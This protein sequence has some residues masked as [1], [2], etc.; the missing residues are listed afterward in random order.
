MS[1]RTPRGEPAEGRSQASTMSRPADGGPRTPDGSPRETME[2]GEGDRVIRIQIQ[3]PAA[4]PQAPTQPRQQP[5]GPPGWLWLIIAVIGLIVVI[6]AVAFIVGAIQG[7]TGAIHQQTGQLAQQ[8]QVLGQ[9]ARGLNTL[10]QTIQQAVQAILGR[11]PA[12]G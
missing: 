9:I 5:S 6:A 11:L 4:T 10:I 1:I 8:S 12:K 7:V 2:R 3:P